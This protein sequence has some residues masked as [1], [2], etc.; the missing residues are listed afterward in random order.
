MRFL[1]ATILVLCLQICVQSQDDYCFGKDTE[2][3]QTRHFTSKT[4]YQII[5]GTNIEKEYLVPGVNLYFFIC[6]LIYY[7]SIII[8]M[9]VFGTKISFLQVLKKKQETIFQIHK[10]LSFY[11]F[12]CIIKSLSIY[13]PNRFL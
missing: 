5:K 10:F 11:H 1:L 4:A 2:R 3:P 12:Y 7:T 9:Y 8:Y 13:T 6:S